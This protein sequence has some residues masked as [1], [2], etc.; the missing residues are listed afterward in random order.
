MKIVVFGS[1]NMDLTAYVPKLPLPGETL[2]GNS[3]ITVPG[4]KGNN[5]AVASARL[6]AHVQFVGRVGDDIFGKQ[7]LKIVAAENVDVSQV[8]VDKE[9]GTG[10]AVISVDENAEN[11]ITVISG[12]NW[13]LDDVDVA[14]A[15]KCL[16]GANALM[17]Q[18]E[19]PLEASMK[20][21]TIA[22]QKAVKVIF[23]PAPAVPLPEQ[24]YKVVD[25][26]TPNET[27]TEILVGLRPQNEMEAGEAAKILHERGVENV[28]IKMGAKGVYYDTPNQK[29]FVKPYKVK[30]IDSV[31]AGDAFNA[32]LAVAIS[33]GK[34]IAEA[35][36]WGAAAGAIA[37]TRKGALPAMPYREELLKLISEQQ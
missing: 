21:A 15:E 23:D 9:K 26:I 30:S 17:L 12:A 1:I 8:A 2:L 7:V 18:L 10:L 29:G 36:R 22:Q 34:S 11:S 5:Q 35:V 16:D 32:G 13:A 20:I 31:A 14:R 33:E 25:F 4:G 37:T 24:V 28:I 6:G 3:Y 19:V 27:E